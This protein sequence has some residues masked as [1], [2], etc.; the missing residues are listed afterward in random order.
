VSFKKQQLFSRA[1]P[2]RQ[3][4]AAKTANIWRTVDVGLQQPKASRDSNRNDIDADRNHYHDDGAGRRSASTE[5]EAEPAE[6]V[7]IFFGLEVLDGS[8]YTVE[9]DGNGSK[10]LKI[11]EEKKYC[12]HDDPKQ[13]RSD[14][15][16]K[17]SATGPRIVK[18]DSIQV[19]QLVSSPE[20]EEEETSEEKPIKKR[21]KKKPKKKKASTE[22]SRSG[23][24]SLLDHAD[25]GMSSSSPSSKESPEVDA[26]DQ[27]ALLHS[28]QYEWMRD[29]NVELHPCLLQSLAQQ[30]F[31]RP[32]PIQSATLAAAVLGRRNVVGAAPTGSGKTAAFLLPIYQHL[33]LALEQEEDIPDS[34]HRHLPL[35]ALVMTPTRE[36]AL[37]IH[38]EAIKLTKFVAAHMEKKKKRKWI[39]CLTGGLA[40][41]KQTRVL[42]QQPAVVVATPGRLW[43]M[44]RCSSFFVY[45]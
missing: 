36:L 6:G 18:S 19:H 21:K 44:V 27:Q 17:P 25:L 2:K 14:G 7:G 30:N 45:N 33:L 15:K 8:Q 1:M 26:V 42:Q 31:L 4:T 35:Q 13:G 43:E 37:Q 5:L 22:E 28:I 16:T 20:D 3:R 39:G 41:A 32:T 40:M 29:C 23:N 34:N 12:D 38:D 11:L 10:R 9:V 24:V